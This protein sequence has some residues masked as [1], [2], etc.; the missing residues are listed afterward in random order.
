M[1]AGDVVVVLVM[2]VGACF[3]GVVIV[4]MIIQQY[5]HFHHHQMNEWLDE[6]DEEEDEPESLA[7]SVDRK[8]ILEDSFAQFGEFSPRN[9]IRGEFDVAFQD[10]EVS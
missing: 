9:I 1:C 6:D 7:L 5:H 3:G 4:I 8:K 10:E 2:C